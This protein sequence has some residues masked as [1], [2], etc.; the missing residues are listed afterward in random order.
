[1]KIV[2]DRRGCACWDPAC[3]SHFSWHFLREE[4]TPIDCVV[5]I[6]D[7]GLPNRTFLIKDKNH[8]DKV[9]VVD[10]ENWSEAYD[11]WLQAWERQQEIKP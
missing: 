3:E 8:I 11:S 9:L 7:D 4:I 5:E 1:M 2:L 6:C 10:E